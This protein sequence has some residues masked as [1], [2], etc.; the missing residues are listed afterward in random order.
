ME[1]VIHYIWKHRILE[2]ELHTTDGEKIEVID[3]GIHNRDEG[4]DFFN[5]KIK[6]GGTMWAGN[7]EIHEKA[8]DWYRHNHQN[9]RAYDNVILHVCLESDCLIER[10]GGGHLPQMV[11]KCPDHVR[12]NYDTLKRN[13]I[14]PRCHTVIA[15]VPS[16]IK[17]SWLTSLQNERLEQKASAIYALMDRLT[18]NIEDAFFI[19]LARSFGFGVNSDAFQQWAMSL[20]LRAV[21]K[22]RDNLLQVESIFFGM[23]GLLDAGS[24]DEYYMQLKQEF[25][26]LSH[27]FSLQRGETPQW[28][29]LRMRP[30][31]FP[32]IRI[33]QLAAICHSRTNLFSQFMEAP[34]AAAVRELLDAPVS[35]Y[36]RVHSTFGHPTRESRRRISQGTANLI[37]I[38]TVVPFVYVYG[39][40]KNTEGTAEKIDTIMESIP[41][42]DNSIT[43]SWEKA[44]IDMKTAADSQAVIQLTKN[45]CMLRKCLH[46]RFGYEFLKNKR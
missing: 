35:D 6:I 13:D 7:V 1:N 40:M 23:A 14:F 19:T 5:A 11:I 18:G 38:N 22:H 16:I 29:M 45:Y 46:C 41:A 44:G 33:A 15:S 43:R 21:D 9:N 8:S 32:H 20:P 12:R 36:W 37:T 3:P 34:T 27:K 4:P 31:N 25:A 39:K 28:K 17:R 10:P 30:G 2:P 26:F 24:G 42:E